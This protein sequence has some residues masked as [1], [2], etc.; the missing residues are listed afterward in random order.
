MC[1]QVINTFNHVYTSHKYF[2]SKPSKK[3]VVL[4][5]NL[6]AEAVILSNSD[7]IEYGY[8]FP[9][10]ELYRNWLNNFNFSRIS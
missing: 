4:T 1:T 6:S 9:S 8:Y 2:Q 10:S 3:N 5:K 7:S